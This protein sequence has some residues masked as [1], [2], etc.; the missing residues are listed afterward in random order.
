[1][2]SG[3]LVQ[4]V[5]YEAAGGQVVGQVERIVAPLG[6]GG[7]VVGQRVVQVGGV[8][9]RPG[10]SVGGHRTAHRAARGAEGAAAAAR[11]RRSGRVA[12]HAQAQLLV[13]TQRGHGVVEE[14][15]GV[16]APNAGQTRRRVTLQLQGA[17]LRGRA[18]QVRG[19]RVL[20]KTM[21]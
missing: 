6:V 3:R 21:G 16:P 20:Q 19:I 2:G 1:V 5:V 18:V 8:A 11:T 4:A 14:R 17:G 15:W 12:G 10:G 9:P 7:H 13:A